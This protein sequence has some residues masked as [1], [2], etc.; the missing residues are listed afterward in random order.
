MNQPNKI[1]VSIVGG[2]GYAGGELL[3]LLLNHP[4]VEVTQITSRSMAGKKVTLLHPNLRKA[5]ELR[6]IKPEELVECDLLFLA[7]PHGEV[8]GRL[9]EY[10]G[11]AKKIIDV[12]AD[13]RLK[14]PADYPRWYDLIHPNPAYLDKFVCGL[15]ELYREKIRTADLVS[16]F[17]CEATCSI[18]SLYPLY[19][20]NLIDGPVFLDVKIGSS[21]AGAKSSAASHHPERANS[22]RSYKLTGHRHMAEIRQELAAANIFLSATAIEMVRGI[23]VTAQIML[24]KD[25]NEADILN[26]Y[27]QYYQKESF[28]RII[29][30]KAG[31]Y[32]FPE[33]KLLA[34]TN[35][36]DIGFEKEEGTNR[37]VVVGAIDNL[38]KGTA[39]QAI[40]AMN[41]MYGWDER[42]SLE[43]MGLHPV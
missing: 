26:V 14:N 2:S 7:M 27:R 1:K 32:R 41:L 13:F 15:A 16:C 21:A 35:F 10:L 18:L 5:T 22:V 9:D 12:S 17:G 33:P 42:L 34:G 8:M 6:F 31:I 30:E 20:E 40:Q 37:L 4:H 24:N 43:F 38:V 29:N 28:I 3:R 11:K 36:C 23:V 19:K 39:G 25:L